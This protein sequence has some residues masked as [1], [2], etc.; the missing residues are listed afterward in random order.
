ML[1]EKRGKKYS[2]Q[3]KYQEYKEEKN[4]V[5]KQNIRNTNISDFLKAGQWKN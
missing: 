2:S 3:T 5:H 1:P 4:T